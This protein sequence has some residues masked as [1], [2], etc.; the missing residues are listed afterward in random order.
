MQG[1]DKITEYHF[2]L[3]QTISGFDRRGAETSWQNR[4]NEAEESIREGQQF[5]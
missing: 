5:W 2:G 1:I 3:F 4:V